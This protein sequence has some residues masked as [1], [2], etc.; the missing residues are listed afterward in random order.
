MLYNFKKS[1]PKIMEVGIALEMRLHQV[2]IQNSIYLDT[3]KKGKKI[4]F[5]IL[6][7]LHSK[8]DNILQ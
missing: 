5:C 1:Q 4:T 8:Y 7:L 3:P 6:F 2:W